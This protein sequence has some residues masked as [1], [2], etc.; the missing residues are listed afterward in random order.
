MW[1]WRERRGW[2]IVAAT[3]VL[4]TVLQGALAAEYREGRSATG[5]E[6]H[7]A[8]RFYFWFDTGHQALL[9][10][11]VVSDLHFDTPDGINVVL[12]G[13]GGYT[14]DRYW[15]VELQGHGTELDVRSSSLGKVREYSN[16]TVLP[17]VR[18]RWPF[19]GTPWM[20]WIRAGLGF[21]LNDV[22]DTGNPRVKLDADET[23]IAG[24]LA[25]GLD[26]FVSPNVALGLALQSL[27]YPDQR[28]TFIYRDA[29]N[30][31]ARRASEDFNLSSQGA[32]AY[33]RLFPGQQATAG[34][35]S[36]RRLFLSEV[37]PFD[38]GDLRGYLYLFGGHTQLFHDEFGGPLGLEAPGDFNATLGGALGINLSTHWGAEIQLSNSDPNLDGRPYGKMAEV[39][40]FTVLPLLR[41]R[42]PLLGGRLVPFVRAGVGVAFFEINDK[43][44]ALDI[45]KTGT[46]ARTVP[47]PQVSITDTSVAASIQPGLEFFLN[48]HLSVGLSFP[49][50]V[51]PEL[52]TTVKEPGRP[53]VRGEADFSGVAGVLEIRAYVP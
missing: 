13:G 53:L 38:T 30:R 39:S 10:E 5:E 2:R 21:S 44:S 14:L 31:I 52:D 40:N 15:S 27:I 18:F 8:R 33:I 26:Y 46:T 28:A 6:V 25:L 29:Q 50:F 48:H 35:G 42:W 37:G 49:F 43:R 3:A 20:P 16:I 24:A 23:T 19:A 32:L 22:N 51:Y 47:T 41:F 4:S 12:G 45:D 9:D 1:G 36:G 7:D 11:H 34:D 17:S